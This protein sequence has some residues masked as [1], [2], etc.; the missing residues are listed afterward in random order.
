[1]NW[2]MVAIGIQYFGA[3]IVEIR[4]HNWPM[5]VVYICYGVSAIAL[6]K[7]GH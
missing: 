6:G 5:S 7:V 1:V 2:F 4:K 3:M